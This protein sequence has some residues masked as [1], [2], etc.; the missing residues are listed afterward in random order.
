M[1]VITITLSFTL[2]GSK[3]ISSD[4]T[5]D[6]T[7]TE[8]VDLSK[9][10]KERVQYTGKNSNIYTFTYPKCYKIED[11]GD[12]GSTW[13]SK[14]KSYEYEDHIVLSFTD[15]KTDP[16]NCNASRFDT[17][18]YLYRKEINIA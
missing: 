8:E 13:V 6:T 14:D 17:D 9:D 7:T 15:A 10:C 1:V 11:Y 4:T 3:T 2:D 5:T 18:E 12:I 16:I